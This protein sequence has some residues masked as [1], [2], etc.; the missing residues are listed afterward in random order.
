MNE[1]FATNTVVRFDGFVVGVSP[2]VGRDVPLLRKRLVAGVTFEWL[3]T[4][5]GQIVSHQTAKL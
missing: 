4:S 1:R 3:C 2:F 5:V